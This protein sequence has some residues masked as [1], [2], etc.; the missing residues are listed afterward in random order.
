MKRRFQLAISVALFAGCGGAS[1]IA[2][3]PLPTWLTS[4][5]R[6]LESQPPANPRAFIARYEYKGQIVY[7]EPQRCCDVPSRVYWIDG[8]LLC[9]PDGGFSGA[10]DG[11]CPDFFAERKNEKVIW[12]DSR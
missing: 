9:Q 8:T 11:R 2:P 3:D 4:L 1:P 10:G 6:N 12:R 7:F 5:I